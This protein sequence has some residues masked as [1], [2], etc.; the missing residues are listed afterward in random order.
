MLIGE[1]NKQRGRKKSQESN[2]LLPKQLKSFY[3][4]LTL[5]K[6]NKR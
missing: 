3:D 6:E 2:N 4:Y 5:K 1:E